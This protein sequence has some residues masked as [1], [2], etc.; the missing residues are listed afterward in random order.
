M[1]YAGL[2]FLVVLLLLGCVSTPTGNI[3]VFGDA[4]KGITDKFDAVIQEYND[5]NIQNIGTVN[6]IV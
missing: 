1:K 4:T 2:L 5:A 3:E 6:L